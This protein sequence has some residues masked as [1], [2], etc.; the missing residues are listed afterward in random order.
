MFPMTLTHL[1]YM[2]NVIILC[3]NCYNNFNASILN[4]LILP[5]DVDFLIEF[6]N[7]DFGAR[8]VV[9]Y[10]REELLRDEWYLVQVNIRLLAE[11]GKC[12]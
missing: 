10:K 5:T 3:F 7:N 4:L 11:N 6:E 1:A 12:I 8:E 2:D 9:I